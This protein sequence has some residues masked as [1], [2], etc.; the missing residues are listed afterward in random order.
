MRRLLLLLIVLASTSLS[1]QLGEI[2]LGNY[3][4]DD[5]ASPSRQIQKGLQALNKGDYPN[6]QVYIGAALRQNEADQHA[7]YLRGEWAMRTG[8]FPIAEGSWKRLVKRCPGYKPDLLFFIAT[9]AIEAGRP[10]EAEGYLEQ[11]F[12]RDDRE[13]GYEKEAE[14]LLAEINLKESFFANPVPFDPKPARNLNTRWDEYLAAL[15][16][17][18]SSIYFTRRSRKKNKYDGPGAQLRNVEEFSIAATIGVHQGMPSFEEGTALESPFNTQ[19]NEGGPSITADNR[20]MVF[21][22][23]ER[24]PKTRVQ[25]CDLYYTT[26]EYGYWNSIRPMPEEVN[27]PDSWESQ[28]SISPNGDVLYFTS[29]RKGGYGGLDLYSSTRDALGN[30][31]TPENLGPAVNTKK[32]EKSPFI[33]PDSESLYFASDGHPGMGGYD[34][35]KIQIPQRNALWGK[36]MNLGY[37]INTES[38]EIGLMVTLDGQKAY[39]AS[40]KINQSN[41]WDIYFFD[42]YEAVQPEEVVLV[43]GQLKIDQFAS[44]D[45]PKVILKNS[46]TGES[47]QLQ[48]SNDDNSFAAVVKKEEAEQ[49][50]LQ[51]EAKKAAFSAAPL[52][53]VPNAAIDGAF[54]NEILVELDHKELESGEAYPIPHILFETASDR[55]DAQSELLITSFAEYLL[56][57]PSLRVQI[58]GHTDN[59]G[60]ADKNLDLSQRRAK[61]VAETII[62]HGISAN[63]I[64]HRGY[65]ESRPV[66]TNDSEAGRAQNRRTV[67]VVTAL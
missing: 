21:T 64:T 33:H 48:L 40:N 1:A 16:P 60:D 27:R 51:V 65:G 20:F 61:R 23:C 35:F 63:R 12:L 53:L 29:D 17:D 45:S 5:H 22:I 43:K 6:A 4:G 38:D 8:K 31:G 32:N 13:L 58:Q 25:N 42:L 11:W 37:P 49:V 47:Q 10:E 50:L 18:G 55:L 56:G 67:F 14:N 24:N 34:L 57:A 15:T 7:L 28:P 44:D 2:A 30:W 66:A 46:V 62:N 39:F 3:C 52:R 19:Y 41:G 26:F 9:L 36:P 59:V 54:S